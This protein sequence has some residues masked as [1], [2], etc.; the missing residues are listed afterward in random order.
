VAHGVGLDQVGHVGLVKHPDTCK[1]VIEDV[2]IGALS[3][4]E[5]CQHWSIVSIGALSALEF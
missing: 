2:G 1:N 5:H 4:L 3:A